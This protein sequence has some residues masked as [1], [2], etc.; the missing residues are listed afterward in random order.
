MYIPDPDVIY[1]PSEQVRNLMA[2]GALPAR[3]SN[4]LR[5]M[6]ID[7]SVTDIRMSLKEIYIKDTRDIGKGDIYLVTVVTDNLSSE[8]FTITIKTFEDIH[9]EEN[10]QIGPGG[11]AIYRNEPGK[12]P[13]FLDYRI[14][15]VE[16]D[17]EIRQA[18]DVLEEVKE[19]EQYKSFRDSLSAM[20]GVSQPATA[21]ITVAADFIM[22]LVARVLRMNRDDQIIYVAGSFD[23]KFDDLGV[24]Y[25][26]V[27]HKNLYGKVAY[28]VEA[29]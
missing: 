5:A 27:V 8:P 1:S 10:L 24:K 11:L 29:L 15:V 14:L 19:D 6:S 2:F 18:V 16:S 9:N 26:L 3:V 23:D 12:I 17:Q 28:Q 13:R 25:G 4:T 22:G 7:P 21:L 20:A